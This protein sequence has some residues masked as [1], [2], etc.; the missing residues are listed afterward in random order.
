MYQVDAFADRLFKGNPAAVVPLR[1]W[2]PDNIMQNIAA[3]NNLAETAF[4]VEH[5]DAFM[6]RWFTPT[7]EVELC[8]HATLASAHVLYE[9][10]G[11]QKDQC[12]FQT[13]KRGELLVSKSEEG[14][15]MNF[16]ADLPRQISRELYNQIV[17]VLGLSVINIMQGTDDV[18]VEVDDPE[19]VIDF[20]PDFRAISEIMSRGILLTASGGLN[21]D[22]VSRCFFPRYGIDEDPVT[23]S[24]HTLLT[25]YW[26]N[27]ISRKRMVALQASKRSGTLIC[28]QENDRIL[29]TGRAIT[30][31]EGEINLDI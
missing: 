18:L 17:S 30:Y 29:L 27:K 12:H 20:I 31:L 21:F 9:H 2:L 11:Y 3:E 7:Q 10:L 13:Q 5:Q 19:T 23:G 24:A 4:F 14:L 22:F 15:T 16:P 6:I 28:E 26:S 25:P 8:G 1:S